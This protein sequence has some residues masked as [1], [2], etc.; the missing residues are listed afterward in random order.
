M[1]EKRY[2]YPHIFQLESGEH[3]AEFELTYHTF[4]QL[5]EAKDNVVWVCHALTGNSNP[6]EWWAG[7]IGEGKLYDPAGYF[8]VCANMLGGCYGSTGPLSLN[9]VT[10]TQYYHQFPRLNNTDVARAF[11]LLRQHLGIKKVHTLIGGSMGGQQA[12][13]WAI[14]KPVVFQHLLVMATNA[15]H[16]AWGIAFNET[17]RMAIEQDISWQL[18]SPKAGLEGMKTARALAMLS[19]RTYDIYERK[20]TDEAGKADNFRASS[21]QQ[22]QG[23]KLSKRFNAF[24]YYNFTRM[25]D[26]HDVGRNR[27]GAEKALAAIKAKTLVVGIDSDVLFPPKEQRFLAKHIPDAQYQEISSDYGHD[28]FLVETEVLTKVIKELYHTNRTLKV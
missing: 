15:R 23:E 24:T 5:N 11:E 20:Q 27:G 1:P 21:Y 4:G 25:M 26:A 3:L 18:K 12:L 17:Q 13:E 28:A 2:H 22:Y 19:Y 16:S 14:Q 9:P 8:I 6:A 10:H 7:L